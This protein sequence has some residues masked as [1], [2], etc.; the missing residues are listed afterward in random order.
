MQ[1]RPDF[2][3]VGGR[4]SI[5]RV[6]LF[7]SKSLRSV[8]FNSDYDTEDIYSACGFH[9]RTFIRNIRH[10]LQAEMRDYIQI[11]G[12]DYGQAWSTL[13]DQWQPPGQTELPGLK[14][15]K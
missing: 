14:E 7:A 12:D 3:I 9:E 4:N 11:F 1:Q 13:F 15:L 5:G 8:E 6:Y 2:V 10:S